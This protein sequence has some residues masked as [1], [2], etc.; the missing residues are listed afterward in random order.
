MKWIDRINRAD[1]VSRFSE[2][3]KSK[4]TNF[5]VCA[6]GEK[7]KLEKVKIIQRY[8]YSWIEYFKQ[9][10][11]NKLGLEIRDLGFEFMHNI[12]DDRISMARQTYNKIQKLK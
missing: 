12:K 2:V 11:G 6:I 5:K 7:F 9:K 3:D 10:F 4:A 1:K 8:N